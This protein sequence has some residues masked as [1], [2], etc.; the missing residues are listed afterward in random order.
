M[1]QE[2][3]NSGAPAGQ[4]GGQDHAVSTAPE[5]GVCCMNISIRPL[6]HQG[7]AAE[8]LLRQFPK[9]FVRFIMFCEITN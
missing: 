3:N 6:M 4:D 9:G 2:K 7:G 8:A 1:Q 5:E